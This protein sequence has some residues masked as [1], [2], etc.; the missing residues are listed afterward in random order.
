[1]SE[2]LKKDQWSTRGKDYM[3]Q[4]SRHTVGVSSYAPDEGI[5]RWAV[6][7]YIYPK[8]RHF[9]RFEGLDMWQEAASALP[10]HA[11]PS[12]LRAH[13]DDEGNITSYQVGSDYHHL[14]DDRFAD[15]ADLEEAYE[16]KRDA[17]ELF[18]WLAPL[19]DAE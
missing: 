2:W 4:I 14:Y 8:H 1:M 19:E 13:R 18:D 7:A 5:N 3:V 15:Y 6:Y 9:S 16:V 17:Q 11:G 12:Y 10:L